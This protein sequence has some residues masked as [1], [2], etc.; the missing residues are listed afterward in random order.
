MSEHSDVSEYHEGEDLCG[1][2]KDD[3][4]VPTGSAVVAQI[5]VTTFEAVSVCRPAILTSLLKGLLVCGD[6]VSHK[7]G[8]SSRSHGLKKDVAH[9]AHSVDVQNMIIRFACAV[10]HS[11]LHSL[12][13]KFPSAICDMTNVLDVHVPLLSLLPLPMLPTTLFP[14]IRISGHSA[15]TVLTFS[16]WHG[17]L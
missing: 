9:T 8:I 2:S 11:A 4:D 16:N 17:V 12:C 7:H 10:Y 13:R 5:L 15:G 1:G 3:Q 6:Y 14:I